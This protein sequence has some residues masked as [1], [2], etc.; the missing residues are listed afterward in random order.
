MLLSIVMPFYRN[1]T[2]LECQLE[3]WRD[4]WPAELKR[5]C[6]AIIVDDGSPEPADAVVACEAPVRMP[7]SVFRVQE[8]RPWHQHGARN[9]GAHVAQAPW[10]LM[11]DMDHVIPA[12]TL[13]EALRLTT[14]GN[15]VYT[16]ARRDAPVGK[17]RSSEWRGMAL[18]LNEHGE[19][20]PHVNSF[21]LPRKL[22]WRA[23]GYDE[24]YCG[25]YGTDKLFRTRLFRVRQPIHLAAHPLIRVDR[26]VIADASTVG[27]PRKDHENRAIKKKIALDK[28]LRGEADLI[29]TLQF[30]WERVL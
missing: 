24:D 28:M 17:W 2:M 10:L 29:K 13:E 5:Q 3:V 30:A 18:T 21:L 7:I 26:A 25:V 14:R 9:L 20:K 8:D 23:G 12:D 16:F 27:L 1:S 19:L 4:E 15:D 22:Y 6:E 11:T